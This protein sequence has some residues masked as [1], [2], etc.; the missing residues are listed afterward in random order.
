MEEKMMRKLIIMILAPTLILTLFACGSGKSNSK[1]GGLTTTTPP[2]TMDQSAELEL[3]QPVFDNLK[4][5]IATNDYIWEGVQEGSGLSGYGIDNYYYLLKD[6]D[7]FGE[8]GNIDELLIYMDGEEIREDEAGTVIPYTLVAVFTLSKGK[9]ILLKEFWSRSRGYLTV[10]AYILNEW[11]N[12]AEDSG[13][14]VYELK[15]GALAKVNIDLELSGNYEINDYNLAT[16][17]APLPIPQ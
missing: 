12:G 10:G 11:S 15:N 1:G 14:T 7:L 8:G 6:L 17:M 5:Q 13:V 4:S 3:Y 9:P 16:T 2:Q